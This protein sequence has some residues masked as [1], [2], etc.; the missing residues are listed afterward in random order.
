M[1]MG[2]AVEEVNDWSYETFDEPLFDVAPEENQIYI[3]LSLLS[4][5]FP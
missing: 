3:T 2:V 5:I 1:S 4:E